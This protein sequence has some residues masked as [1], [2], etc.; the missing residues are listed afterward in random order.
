MATPRSGR[1][2]VRNIAVSGLAGREET[3]KC[4]LNPDVN[5]FFGHNGSGKTTLLRIIH[6]ALSGDALQLISSP[7]ESAEVEIWYPAIKRKVIKNFTMPS[8]EEFELLRRDPSFRRN[9]ERMPPSQRRQ[10]LPS[11]VTWETVVDDDAGPR[12]PRSFAHRYLPT[13][14]VIEGNVSSP[15]NSRELSMDEYFADSIQ[16][17]WSRYSAD[18]L[19][20]VRKAQEDGLA[21]ILQGVIS[22]AQSNPER[23]LDLD[24]DMAFQRVE[25][26]LRRQGSPHLLQD[27]ETFDLR[28]ASE[29]P[30][31]RVVLEINEVEEQIESALLPRTKLEALVSRLISGP[32]QISFENSQIRVITKNGREVSLDRLSS[33]EKQVIRI[34][35]ETL[36][37]SGHPLIIDEPEL[38]MHINWQL[39]LL[40]SIQTID[41]STQVIAATHSPEIMANISDEKIFKL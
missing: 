31:N 16:R 27:K 25:R 33:G 13:S 5:I 8:D 3:F 26:F 12:I 23:T 36:W 38:S 6:S 41:E 32:K 35:V 30:F 2:Y 17:L 15:E 37:A 24:P 11:S 34:L 9:V 14:R 21:R 4:M 39:D 40:E 10:Y 20:V 18:V 1:W 22:P 19:G 28:F 29:R 7:F